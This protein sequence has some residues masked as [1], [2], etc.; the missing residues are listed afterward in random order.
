MGTRRLSEPLD[1]FLV[2]RKALTRSVRR[3]EPSVTPGEVLPHE[4]GREERRGVSTRG[5]GYGDDVGG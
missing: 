3:G 4:W 2:S 1:P 5:G